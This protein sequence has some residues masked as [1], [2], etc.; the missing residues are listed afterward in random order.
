MHSGI[1]GG[2]VHEPL[3]DM[4]RLLA[5]LTSSTDGE[6]AIPQFYDR[7][8]TMGEVEKE[9]LDEVVL[10]DRSHEELRESGR[11]RESLISR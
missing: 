1:Q 9:L 4:V 8:S 2:T 11:L 5:T 7:V 3:I 6:I 10:R